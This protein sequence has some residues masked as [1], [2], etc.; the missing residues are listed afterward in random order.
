MVV[1]RVTPQGWRA[2]SV[3]PVSPDPVGS[4]LS[5][6][7]H[8]TAPLSPED[9]YTMLMLMTMDTI[10]NVARR[11]CYRYYFWSVLYHGSCLSSLLYIAGMKRVV[12]IVIPR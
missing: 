2:R 3:L 4:V 8:R 7:P 1:L 6:L 12:R 9:D 11:Q 5:I 10:L